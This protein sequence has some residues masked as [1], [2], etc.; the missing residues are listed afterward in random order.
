MFFST[1]PLREALRHDPHPGPV[2][3]PEGRARAQRGDAR[4]LGGEDQFVD[5]PLDGGEPPRQRQ[6]AGDV[7]RVE[8]VR[9]HAG[10]QQ[11]QFVRVEP[12]VVVDPVQHA[13][14]GTRGRDRV[15]AEA[16]AL[17]AG[18]QAE[19]ALDPALAARV[20]E[21]LRQGPYDVLEPG[22]GVV[23]GQL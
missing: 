16:V 6:G 21:G 3:V 1:P 20:R 8:G 23:D 14:V 19:D 10:V 4:L 13:G 18:A 9:L 7:R 11:Q 15:V 5:L 2:E 12:A 17:R 22:R